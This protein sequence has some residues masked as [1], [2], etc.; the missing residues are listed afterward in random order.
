MLRKYIN[1]VLLAPGV[2]EDAGSP[3]ASKDVKAD[4]SS[5]TESKQ[6]SEDKK[7]VKEVSL[8][9]VTAKI[10]ADAAKKEAQEESS[11]EK[12]EDGS[13][14][15]SNQTEKEEDKE[16]SDSADKT[17][18]SE[19]K[20][21]D[22][23]TEK[24]HE[25]AVPYARFQETVQ[26]KQTL[27]TKVKEYEP[28]VAAHKSIVE[29]CQSNQITEEQFQNG[30]D[31]LR[32]VN[33][34]P[35]EARK[36]L[37]PIWNQLNGLAGETLPEDLA[38]EVDEGTISE[39]RAK[40]IARLRGQSKIQGAKS[41]LS[42][43]Q[44]QAQSQ[45]LF[46]RELNQTITS[47]TTSKQTTDPGFKPKSADQPDG[48]FEYV[49][50]RVYKLMSVNVP[51]TTADA[52]KL[53]EQAYTEVS[54]SLDALKPKTQLSTKNVSSTKTST[55]STKVPTTMKEVVEGVLSRHRA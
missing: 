50:D 22:E 9:D 45:Q 40:E 36:R 14:L 53:V 26:A 49:A 25:E 20:V 46:Q 11:T 39:N 51:K 1:G 32:L 2:N 47:W 6:G 10:V 41:Q 24:K 48:K 37:E 5:D 52:I 33:T 34:D 28:L 7:D 8:A 18:D 16:E 4:S 54:K 15:Q 19:K 35:I 44:Q 3:D 21:E 30:M 31:M 23:G 17:E 42:V 38:K 29:F 27:E 12:A 43:Q 55:N 13:I